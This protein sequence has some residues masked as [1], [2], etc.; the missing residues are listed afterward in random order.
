MNPS[1]WWQ[2]LQLGETNI[3]NIGGLPKTT[4][5]KP[6]TV[7]IMVSLLSCQT[8]KKKKKKSWSHLICFVCHSLIRSIQSVSHW[9]SRNESLK[10]QNRLLSAGRIWKCCT[11]HA[12]HFLYSPSRLAFNTI[13]GL[14]D[15]SLHYKLYTGRHCLGETSSRCLW[16]ERVL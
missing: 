3:M 4:E 14:Q 2:A 10:I 13:T 8:G 16:T 11:A 1:N 12:T 7:T 9:Q 5:S 6:K 15:G